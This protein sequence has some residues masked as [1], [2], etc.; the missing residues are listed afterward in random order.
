[1]EEKNKFKGM[2]LFIIGVL[3]VAV[4]A[5]VTYIILTS[6]N[7][8]NVVSF[9][10]QTGNAETIQQTQQEKN[11]IASE[12]NATEAEIKIKELKEKGYNQVEIESNLKNLGSSD[13]PNY[14]YCIRW[15]TYEEDGT[16]D[17]VIV[18]L[19]TF[20]KMFINGKDTGYKYKM[21]FGDEYS[22][23][24]VTEDNYLYNPNEMNIINN[25]KI[26]AILKYNDFDNGFEYV[27][28][29]FEDGNIYGESID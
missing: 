12:K 11:E 18:Y 5:L 19:D 16:F 29:V 9:T 25:S 23:V 3:V 2:N 15:G 1:M 7:N 21:H 13:N 22:G 17:G 6:S 27:T 26:K 24:I 14:K 4:V 28:V 20:G 8:Q 10:E